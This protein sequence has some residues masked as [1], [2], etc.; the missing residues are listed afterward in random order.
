[1]LNPLRWW[2]KRRAE[3]RSAKEAR[4]AAYQAETRALF[5]EAWTLIDAMPSGPEKRMAIR[6]ASFCPW[7]RAAYKALVT[8]IRSRTAPPTDQENQ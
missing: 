6:I 1:M 8:T 4:R 2:K 7:N 3:R 5:S